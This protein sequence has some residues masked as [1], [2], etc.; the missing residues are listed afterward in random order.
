MIPRGFPFQTSYLAALTVPHGSGS[1]RCDVSMSR[2]TTGWQNT[3]SGSALETAR[4]PLL[5]V[6]M[7]SAAFLFA[8]DGSTTSFSFALHRWYALGT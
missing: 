7:L 3:W 1:P 5:V 4:N 2:T 8:L 6:M